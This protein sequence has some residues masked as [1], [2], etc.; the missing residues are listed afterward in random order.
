[1]LNK[2]FETGRFSGI[3]SGVL[4]LE[5]GET[6][7]M[8]SIINAQSRTLEGVKVYTFDAASADES[9][10]EIMKDIPV[11]QEFEKIVVSP[12]FVEAL[13]VPRKL[14]NPATSLVSLTYSNN[15]HLLHD[16]IPEWQCVNS[17]AVPSSMHQQITERFPGASFLHTYTPLLK[18]FNGFSDEYQLVVHFMYNQ[19]RVVVKKQQQVHLIQTYS[20]ESP[21]DVVYYLLK[22]ATEFA[23][24]FNETQIIVSGFVEENSALYK[25]MHHYFSNLHFAL[26]S[27][28][29]LP[30]EDHPNHFFTSIHNLAACVL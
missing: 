5:I 21:M 9:I 14:H 24:P 15:T 1:M 18:I 29:L 28:L 6:Y 13:L 27:T 8:V 30:A 19:F 20:Y 22:L 12:A 16:V 2:P 3:E 17:Y 7:C 4:L 25:E 11:E 23:L 26:T 10:T